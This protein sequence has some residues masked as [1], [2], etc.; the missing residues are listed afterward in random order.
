[1][2]STRPAPPTMHT[3]T[4]SV[5]VQ[6]FLGRHELRAVVDVD[7][8]RIESAV[9]SGDVVVTLATA[10][11]QRHLYRMSRVDAQDIAAVLERLTDMV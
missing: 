7:E 5:L 3:P 2:K 1:M 4:D 8:W 9:D 10:D 6:S 11:G